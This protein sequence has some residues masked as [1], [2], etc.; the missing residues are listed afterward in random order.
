MATIQWFPGHMAKALRQIR[1]QMPLVDILFE[2][3]D[4]RVPYSSQNP[5]VALAAGEK[6]K[7]LIMTKTDLA[8]QKRLN[9]WIKYFEQ[10]N[11]PVLA[12]DS[13]Q[14][15]VAKV[16]T[17]RSKEILKGK[18]AEEKAKGMKKRR[19]LLMVQILLLS[20]ILDR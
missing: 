15:N 11:Q 6:P 4:A 13:R 7:L 18:L 3:V 17:A 14:N 9:E 10:H 20:Q 19:H 16:V 5:E 2:L 12:L 1:E 8:D